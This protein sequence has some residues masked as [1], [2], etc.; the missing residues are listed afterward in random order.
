MKKMLTKSITGKSGKMRNLLTLLLVSVAFIG[1]KN[2]EGKFKT[3]ESG[4]EYKYHHHNEE[5]KTAAE[6][7]Y[8]SMDMVYKTESDSILFDSK[9]NGQPIVLVVGKPAYKGDIIEGITMMAE[10]DSATF[11]VVADSFFV[12]NL[13]MDMPEFI[14][15]GSKLKFDVKMNKIQSEEEV[16]K[17][18]EE[19]L[20]EAKGKEAGMLEAYLREN[21]ITA[22]PTPSG[23]Y[24]IEVEKGTGAKAEAGKT[25]SVHYKGMLLDGTVFDTSIEEE[26]KKANVYNPQRPYEPFEFV[27]GTG[28]VIPG[29]DEGISYMNVGGKAKFIIPS[30]LAYGEAGAGGVIPPSAPLVFEVELL[31]VK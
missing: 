6:G 31:G 7:D 1:C 20:E 19:K 16:R 30:Y 29:W 10:G 4:L 28:Q 3:T 27:L 21:N 2:Q 15:K 9:K 24:Y 25:V 11:L 23:L 8:V 26:A 22:V 12:H 14:T 13:Q 17:E 18:Q 5:A